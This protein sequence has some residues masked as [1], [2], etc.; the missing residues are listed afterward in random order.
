MCVFELKIS[1]NPKLE[2]LKSVYIDVKIEELSQV[3]GHDREVPE[4]SPHQQTGRPRP[5]RPGV[6]RV[7]RRAQLRLSPQNHRVL[8]TRGQ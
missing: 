3:R 7:G 5:P 1:K 4:S 6:R 2:S 8:C